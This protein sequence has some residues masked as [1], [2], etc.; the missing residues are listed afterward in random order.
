[1]NLLQVLQRGI[2]VGEAAGI[3]SGTASIGE[4]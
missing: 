1:M 2:T 4:I 3:I